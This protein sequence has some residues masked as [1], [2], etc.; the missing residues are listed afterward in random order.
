MEGTSSK[1]PTMTHAVHMEPSASAMSAGLSLN[2]LRDSARVTSAVNTGLTA[3]LDTLAK[4]RPKVSTKVIATTPLRCTP[5]R[6]GEGG[7]AGLG[8]GAGGEGGRVTTTTGGAGGPNTRG[9]LCEGLLEELEGGWAVVADGEERG[10][11]GAWGGLGWL[12]SCAGGW[13][14]EGGPPEAWP[15]GGGGLL[16]AAG[17]GG[18][19]GGEGGGRYCSTTCLPALD[20][21]H[22]ARPPAA[23][24]NLVE[25]SSTKRYV[26]PRLVASRRAH[27]WG[28]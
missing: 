16:T 6:W 27:T 9:A 2:R 7:G 22:M 11:G 26:D 4:S 8:G 19:G 25:L 15:G 20:V 13:P 12:G 21:W 18:G 14:E 10:A 1:P 17:G 24:T 28:P 23:L 3:G 5:M